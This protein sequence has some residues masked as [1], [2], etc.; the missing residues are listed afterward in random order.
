MGRMFSD[1]SH[2]SEHHRSFPGRGRGFHPGEPTRSRSGFGRGNGFPP[3]FGPGHGFGPGFGGGPR[4][5]GGPG[6]PRRRKG[7]ARDAI[8]SLLAEGPANGYGLIKSISDR[9]GGSWTPSPGSVYPTLQQLVDEGLIEST[10]E[11]KRTEFQLTDAGRTYVGEH[12]DE[13]GAA[14]SHDSEHSAA[15]ADLH[16][17]VAKLMGVIHQIRFAATDDQ[18]AQA[19]AQIDET[20]RALYRILGE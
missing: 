9:T 10:G 5:F 4:G 14:L 20:R 11:D 19:I 15:N 2:S 12:A 7:A 8:L 16:E 18:R 6:G 1:S 13:L 17:S 3:G